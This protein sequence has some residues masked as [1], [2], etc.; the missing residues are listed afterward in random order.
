M[1]QTKENYSD[2]SE[3]VSTLKESMDSLSS[4]RSEL[5]KLKEGSDE[6]KEKVRELNKEVLTL[7][8]NYPK[9]AQ[10]VSNTNGVLSIDDQGLQDYYNEQVGQQQHL[11]DINSAQQVNTLTA[12]TAASIEDFSNKW[13]VSKEEIQSALDS[14]TATLREANTKNEKLNSA[15]AELKNTVEANSTSVDNLN[16]TIGS[17]KGYTD[18]SKDSDVS[19]FQSQAQTDLMEKY[20]TTTRGVNSNGTVNAS[21]TTL[22]SPEL[23]LDDTSFLQDMSEALGKTIVS[24]SKEG[25]KFKFKDS[26]GEETSEYS[27]AELLTL[28]K[29]SEATAKMADEK[30]K[31]NEQIYEAFGARLNEAGDGFVTATGKTVTSL[32]DLGL[33]ANQIT[34]LQGYQNG[35]LSDLKTKNGEAVNSLAELIVAI[36]NGSIEVD[37]FAN[38]LN[39]TQ[40]ETN[41]GQALY[42]STKTFNKQVGNDDLD[43]DE[44]NG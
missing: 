33:S 38:S 3:K 28:L 16:D 15:F 30:F 39:K 24:G 10:Y 14:G 37:S 43:E 44:L 40:A 4:T 35:Q 29:N 9:L 19:D 32:S 36:R 6:W 11:S 41:F 18:Y 42:T 7:I 21:T 26:S 27:S 25:G 20:G 22:F 5:D 34:V 17:G 31:Q 12:S 2:I 8:Q 1:K 13:G 23:H